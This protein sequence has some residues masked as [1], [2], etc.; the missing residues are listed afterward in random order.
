MTCKYCKYSGKDIVTDPL[1]GTER[2]MLIC[3]RYAPRI[4]HGSGYGWS[5][6]KFPIMQD[7]DWC[8]EYEQILEKIQID[9]K[10][11]E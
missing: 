7:T 3:R 9:L 2:E 4:L 5:D 8:G 10:D 1:D 11:E 6:T